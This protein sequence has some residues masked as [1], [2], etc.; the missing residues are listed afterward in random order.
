MPLTRCLS[1][2][3]LIDSRRSRCRVCEQAVKIER[4]R[5]ARA[6][7]PCPQDGRCGFCGEPA[8]TGGKGPLVWG[9]WPKRF[10]DGGKTVVPMHKVCNEGPAKRK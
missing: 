6:L 9:H 7:G 4:S 8:H 10:I 2:S 1:C 3:A 5:Q